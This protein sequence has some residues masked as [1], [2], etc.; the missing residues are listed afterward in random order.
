MTPAR[1]VSIDSPRQRR[2]IA[3]NAETGQIGERPGSYLVNVG[4][5]ASEILR[6]WASDLH[7]AFGLAVPL[8]FLAH[9]KTGRKRD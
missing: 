5:L 4:Y 6:P 3:Q 7:V 1:S 8:L 2:R 9:V